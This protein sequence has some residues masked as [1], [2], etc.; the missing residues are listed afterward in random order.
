MMHKIA[1]VTY[2]QFQELAT[3]DNLTAQCL[4]QQGIEVHSV[5]WDS[6]LVEWKQFDKII[7]RSTWDY[8]LRIE[9]FNLWLES[10]QQQGNLL[11]NPGE[12]IQWNM[13]KVYLKELSE[14]GV[15][16]PSTIWLR[17][18][19]CVQLKEV[20][21]DRGW[22]KAVIKPTISA[23]AYQTWLISP[24]TAAEDQYQLDKMLESGEVMI[25]E[26]VKE[27]QTKG[28]W[29]LVFFNK[30]FSHAVLK[31]TKTN[32]FRVQSSY[33]G[34]ATALAPPSFILREAKR[35]ISL[36]DAPLLYARIDGIEAAGNFI[37]IEVELIEPSLFLSQ[38]PGAS[39]A[40]ADAILAVEA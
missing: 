13:N 37:L 16:I 17:Q 36:I 18:F 25:Q 15:L 31:Q 40:F 4:S 26:F 32:D 38:A 30:Q 39:Q 2:G 22:D 12:V 29:S 14:K 6:T 27:I 24:Q 7:L 8:H 5:S 1:F 9:E 20:L 34:T 3:D 28:E 23:S 33:G 19:A 11:Y 21:T 35:I 10:M